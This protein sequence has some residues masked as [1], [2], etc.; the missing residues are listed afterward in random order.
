ME[1]IPSLYG[2]TLNGF[3]PYIQFWYSLYGLLR[4][5]SQL[6][7]PFPSIDMSSSSSSPCRGSDWASA[8][9][10]DL[11][12]FGVMECLDDRG[13]LDMAGVCRVSNIKMYDPSRTEFWETRMLG[14]GLSITVRVRLS[15]KESRDLDAAGVL[16]DKCSLVCCMDG[17]ISPGHDHIM[18]RPAPNRHFRNPKLREKM[19]AHARQLAI[20]EIQRKDCLCQHCGMF[21]GFPMKR[22]GVNRTH[23]VWSSLHRHPIYPIALCNQCMV[24]DQFRMIDETEFKFKLPHN[25]W[26]NTNRIRSVH[27]YKRHGSMYLYS[28]FQKER[29][30]CVQ[31]AKIKEEERLKQYEKEL[32][33]MRKVLSMKAASETEIAELAMK[34]RLIDRLKKRN[35]HDE[36]TKCDIVHGSH[37]KQRVEVTVD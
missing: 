25:A 2:Y 7:H 27:D 12:L 19:K 26:C 13:V 35:D 9:S 21:N 36:S 6:I 31:E 28:D 4:S 32:V 30:R 1:W 29:K 14:V 22:G 33:E 11:I 5:L 16:P 15:S 10:C 34:T 8:W 17:H 20:D 23:K 37:K 3:H 18:K 24:T